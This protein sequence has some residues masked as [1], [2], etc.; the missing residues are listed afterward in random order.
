MTLPV[1]TIHHEQMIIRKNWTD[2]QKYCGVFYQC[3]KCLQSVLIPSTGI[4]A[5]I[6]NG[7]KLCL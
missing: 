7:V 2:E 4:E 3:P 1:C 6:K 5:I